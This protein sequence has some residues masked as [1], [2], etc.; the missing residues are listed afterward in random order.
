MLSELVEQH[1][2][3]LVVIEHAFNQTHLRELITSHWHLADGQLTTGPADRINT[4]P[5]GATPQWFQVLPEAAD[6]VITE[7]LPRG[8]TLTRFR[9]ASRYKPNPILTIEDLVVKRGNRTV[10]GQDDEGNEPGFNLTIN[11]GEIAVLQAPNGWGKSTLFDAIAATIKT[12][13]GSVQIAGLGNPRKLA[14]FAPSK[15]ALFNNLT[16]LE[17][18]TLA[19]TVVSEELSACLSRRAASL[20]GGQ[21]QRLLLACLKNEKPNVMD[22]PFKGLDTSQPILSIILSPMCKMQPQLLLVPSNHHEL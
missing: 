2:I 20:S 11:E 6:E 19:G 16:V 5:V 17:I 7:P 15:D 8:A 4:Q 9:I 12:T 1:E 18:A 13:R 21:R 3:T 14:G 10:I 22:E